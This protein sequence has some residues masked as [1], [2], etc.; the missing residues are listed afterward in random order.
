MFDPIYKTTIDKRKRKSKRKINKVHRILEQKP[1]I[2][3]FQT[4]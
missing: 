3:H 1:D 4:V 2:I